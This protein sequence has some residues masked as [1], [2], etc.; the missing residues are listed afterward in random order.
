MEIYNESLRDLL[1]ANQKE[2]KEGGAPKHEIKHSRDGVTS[3]TDVTVMKVESPHQVRQLLKR[4]TKNRSVGSTQKNDRSS[5]SHS[6]FQILISGRNT[7][8]GKTAKVFFIVFFF[9]FFLFFWILFVFPCLFFVP[10]L[11]HFFLQ[12]T[13]SLIDLAGSERL[14]TSGAEGQRKKETQY[15]N[16]SLSSLGDVICALANKEVSKEQHNNHNHNHNNKKNCL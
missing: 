10:S 2:E 7:I 8:S 12:A 15:I 11:S 1:S 16:K 3:V 9:S 4:A 14:S 13:L 6:V 5:R